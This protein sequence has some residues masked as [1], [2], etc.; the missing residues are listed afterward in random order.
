[1]S[2]ADSQLS[3]AVAGHCA[4]AAAVVLG[5]AHCPRGQGG[6]HQH[7]PGNAMLA[8]T[9]LVSPPP[10]L[11]TLQLRPRGEEQAPPPA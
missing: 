11:T 2:Q 4:A 9:V 5:G 10:P 6:A 1:V 3:S 7:T 8:T